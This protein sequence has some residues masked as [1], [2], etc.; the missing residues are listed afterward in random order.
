M[1]A[2]PSAPNTPPGIHPDE[3]A[4][5]YDYWA[6]RCPEGDVPDRADIDPLDM[7][8]CLGNLAIVEFEEPFRPRYRLVGSNLVRLYGKELTGCYIDEAY[9]GAVRDEALAVYR[10]V[11]RDRLANYTRRTLRGLFRSYSYDR[12]VLPLRRGGC[13][14]EQALLAIYPA[15]RKLVSAEQWQADEDA[16]RFGALVEDRDYIAE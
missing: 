10:Q 6:S 16:R 12:L 11:A 4:R 5:L 2:G 1:I 3:L 15:D 13:R 7:T 14:I 9:T 8:Y